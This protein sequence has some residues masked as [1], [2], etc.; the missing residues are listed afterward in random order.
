[1]MESAPR[2]GDAF[3]ESIKKPSLESFETL[4]LEEVNLLSRC[5]PISYKSRF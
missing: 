4:K 5:W 2:S 3:I 1:M